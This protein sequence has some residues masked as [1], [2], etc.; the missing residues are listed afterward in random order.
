MG[1]QLYSIL[2]MFLHAKFSNLARVYK[3]AFLFLL[4]TMK[5]LDGFS[6]FDFILMLCLQTSIYDY[7]LSI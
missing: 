5:Q 1:N 4:C 3:F 2:Q 6:T 7:F